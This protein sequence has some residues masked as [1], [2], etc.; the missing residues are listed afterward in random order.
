MAVHRKG[1]GVQLDQRN[2]VIDVLRGMAIL[3]VLLHH[4]GLRVPL[5]STSL[6]DLIPRWFLDGLNFS[7][8]EAV[9][10][11]FVLSGFLIA[12]RSIAR[13]GS[14]GTIDLGAFYVRRF[15]RI[16][17]GM[18]GVV[19]LLSAL[20][21]LR[22]PDFVI[23]G[24][25]QSLE[26]AIASALGLHLNWYEAKTGYLPGGWDVLWSLSIEAV[27]YIGFPVACVLLRSRSLLLSATL[28]LALSLPIARSQI[29]DNAIWQQK[30][31]VPGLSA[32]ALGVAGTLMSTS[33]PSTR[34]CRLSLR[35]CG[36]VGL[37][38]VLFA[39][40]WLWKGLQHGVML[41]LTGSTLCILL[42][43]TGAGEVAR[44][45]RWIARCGRM[46]YEVYLT[47]MLVVLGVCRWWRLWQ[48]PGEHAWLVYLMVVP[49]CLLLGGAYSRYFTTP[50]ERWIRGA[51][52]S[53]TRQTP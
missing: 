33:L 10:T 27:F 47:H 3:F 21:I 31:Y 39:G 24:R 42:S 37:S 19:A 48:W 15:A 12:Q 29:G 17:P 43:A 50:A 51:L 52:L 6:A 40:S 14:L 49:L 8:Y 22:T 20:H 28:L 16:V 36:L 32:I 30:A 2:D 1:G 7:G 44:G 13:W 41:V 4:L 46:S 45:F 18:L 26:G 23:Q 25:E 38:A 34:A 11:F 9:F 35:L 5:R 53:H